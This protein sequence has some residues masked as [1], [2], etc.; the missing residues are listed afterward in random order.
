MPISEFPANANNISL[1]PSIRYGVYESITSSQEVVLNSSSN[2]LNYVTLD[3]TSNPGYVR[4][5]LNNTSIVYG[6]AWI[7]LQITRS[8]SSLLTAPLE[9]PAESGKPLTTQGGNTLDNGSGAATIADLTVPFGTGYS[10]TTPSTWSSV[11]G[12]GSANGATVHTNP[13]SKLAVYQEESLPIGDIECQTAADNGIKFRLDMRGTNNSGLPGLNSGPQW[14][15]L[16]NNGGTSW[17]GPGSD[18]A[19]NFSANTIL[20]THINPNPTTPALP[21]NPPV[22][23]TVYQNTTGGPIE[24]ALPVTG[25]SAADT[26]QWALGSTDAPGDWGGADTV[27][28]AEV[29]TLHLTVPNGWYWSITTGAT[30]GTAD[31]LGS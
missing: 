1:E 30:I 22:S 13:S 18:A 31:V 26:A 20:G 15:I 17:V 10:I 5:I 6:S 28:S 8:S 2:L 27:A 12:E 9:L 25:G 11:A 19:G 3:S 14:Y 24:I 29:K 16:G 21:T 23:G 7:N 4:W